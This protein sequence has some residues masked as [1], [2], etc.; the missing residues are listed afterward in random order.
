MELI[1]VI[2]VCQFQTREKRELIR[3]LIKGKR[4]KIWDVNMRW[5][6]F[7]ENQF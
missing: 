6:N 2:N 7:V 3:V 1:R 4:D 5:G